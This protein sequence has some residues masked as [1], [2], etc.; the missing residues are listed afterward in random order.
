MIGYY[1]K[2]AYRNLKSNRK[3]SVIN[4]AGFAFAIS[5]CLA[6]VLFLIKEYSY[7]R[8]HE[9]ADQIVR[10]VNTKNNSS[11][12]DYRV[13]DI[14]L[15]NYSEFENACLVQRSPR[16]VN[17]KVEEKGFSIDGIMS[18]NNDFFNVFSIEFLQGKSENPFTD[19]NSAIITRSTA[20][21][22]FGTENA[23]GK[24]IIYSSRFPLKI[25][26]V[27]N[28]FPD[29]SSL[30]AGILV[31]AEKKE[32]KFSWSCKNSNDLSSYRWPFRIYCLLNKNI[33]REQLIA[34]VNS[35]V[36]KLAP[37]SG[38]IDFI[39]LKNI[40]LKDNTNGS[41]N[42]RGN[43]ALLKLLSGIAA[44]ILLLAIINYINL[45][46]AQ[47]NKRYKDIGIRKT[48][49]AFRNDLLFN[50]LSESVLVSFIALI[51]SV[52]FVWLL[53]PFYGSVFNTTIDISLLSQFP[54]LI[55]LVFGIFIIGILSGIGPALVLSGI[56]PIQIL[57]GSISTKSKKGYLRNSLT[58]F[59]F[60]ISII[61]IF[62][63]TII[64][65]Q[66]SYVKNKDSGFNEEQ[67]LTLSIPRLNKTDANK[68]YVLL[69]ELKHSPFIKKLSVSN[70]VPGEI[71][72]S[73][74]TN[75]KNSDKNINVPCLIVDTAFIET[76]DIEIIKGRNL[77]PGDFGKVCMVN[78]AFYR[79]F[80]FENLENKRF[81]NYSKDG[82]K[83]IGVLKD[84]H[85]NSLHNS[86]GPACILFADDIPRSVNVR[87]PNNGVIPGI[88]FIKK[89]WKEILPSYVLEFQFYDAWFDAMYKKEER[90]AKTIGLFAILAIIISCIGILG[91]A[92]FTSERRIK[93]IG[94]RKVNGA[95]ISEILSM[96][97]KDFIKWVAIAFV[98]ACPIAYFAMSKWLENF[99]YKTTLSWWIFA[100]A[101][102]LALGIALLTVSWQSWRA[103]TRNP[104]EALRHE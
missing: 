78:E 62:C 44:I 18:V 22:L 12:I 94:I 76:F 73:M 93:E 57:S 19:I 65:R 21:I 88:D 102:V 25:T 86:I 85:Y 51:L 37:Y 40:Y 30:N 17:L 13:K 2:S 35:N 99:A 36:D 33:D 10:L 66:I 42:K 45:T 55:I 92:I 97:N 70:G 48:V 46:V 89:K 54:N 68:A 38:K 53:I 79:H 82:F 59:Q 77:Q 26:G 67:L 24:E 34:K 23:V 91:L 31:N 1:F 50:F 63:V 96:L 69:D 61:L 32:F 28:D 47:Q 72:M 104:V 15:E 52:F 80:E 98:I 8:Y 5:I 3:F 90:F 29:N 6:I 43:L 95:K 56:K 81:N 20:Q 60:A 9:N 14:L 100:L 7:D 74:G 101:G 71:N 11:S 4:I 64:Q 87:L 83:I 39:Q 75:I 49:G 103:A 58:I 41:Q 16:K 27:I 84:F